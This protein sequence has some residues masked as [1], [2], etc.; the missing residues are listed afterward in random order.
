M[1]I[2]MECGTC[3]TQIDTKELYTV[4]E[5][6][7]WKRFHA[8]CVSV[9]ESDLRALSNNMIWI[10]DGCMIHYRRVRQMDVESSPVKMHS[11]ILTELAEL[12]TQVAGII[13]AIDKITRCVEVPP[14]RPTH[15]LPQHSTP[16]ASPNTVEKSNDCSRSACENESFS[17]FVTNIDSSVTNKEV[18][19]MVSDS[20]CASEAEC[21]TITKLVPKWKNLDDLDY[22][23]FKIVLNSKWKETAL[24][25]DT[26]PKGVKIRE[27]VNRR[28]DTWKPSGWMQNTV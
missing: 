7:C 16:V 4:C 23:S 5:G 15:H 13:G 2:D 14:I 26:W 24:T 12:K 27:F 10:C 1:G 21:S 3:S 28:G 17:L 8:S 20:L 19:R 22:V 6:R 18:A 25:G 11:P 9:T